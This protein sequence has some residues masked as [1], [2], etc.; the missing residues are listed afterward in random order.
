MLGLPSSTASPRPSDPSGNVIS[1]PIPQ[2]VGPTIVEARLGEPT[3]IGLNDD[4]ATQRSIRRENESAELLADKGYNVLQN[5]AVAGPKK[6]DYLINGEIY[7]PY[8]PSTD[9][10]I[11]RRIIDF[12]GCAASL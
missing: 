7:D 1:T 8:A 10:G 3:P 12:Q 4:E 6:A 2:E 9:R 5:P 11:R